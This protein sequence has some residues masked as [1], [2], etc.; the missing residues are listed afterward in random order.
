MQQAHTTSREQWLDARRRHSAG[1]MLGASEAGAVLGW[2]RF[3]DRF[4]LWHRKRG[5]MPEDAM[6]ERREAGLAL[7]S[8]ILRWYMRRT[9]RRLAMPDLVAACMISSHQ[10]EY[11][12][13]QIEAALDVLQCCT[14]HGE[15][16]LAEGLAELLHPLFVVHYGPD[17]EGRVTLRS[18][19]HPWL[20]FSPDA[21][22]HDDARGW[23][24][25][26]AKN[27]DWDLAWKRGEQVPPEYSA[28]IAQSTLATPF[29]WGGFA[30]C[31]AGQKLMVVD[32]EREAMQP[33]IDLL[34]VEAP[35]FVEAL[36]RPT[37]P[38]PTGSDA[39]LA[40]LRA[41]WPTHDPQKAVAW[42]AA[43]EA[44]EDKHA[45]L[46]WDAMYVDALEQRRAWQ[47][48]VRGL[49]VVLRYV[50]KDAGK[51]V[52][53]MGITYTIAMEGDRERIRRKVRDGGAR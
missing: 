8:A 33:V 43:I 41:L 2:S 38:P 4:V 27:I 25:V 35:A 45:P 32:V 12:D 19:E 47:D 39:A 16:E 9:D 20:A 52:L 30:V 22:A 40:C 1:W 36:D 28:Q 50:A 34:L 10:D 24:V 46:E 37:P 29:T 21:F 7:E 23:G 26:D 44:A 51:V 53:P 49:E 15:G 6:D 11:D 5:L 14:D 31:V 3:S 17:E 42:V 13:D 48:T 18:R